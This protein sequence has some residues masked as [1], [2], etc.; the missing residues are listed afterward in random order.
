MAVTKGLQQYTYSTQYT[1]VKEALWLYLLQSLKSP[2]ESNVFPTPWWETVPYRQFQDGLIF[3]SAR[4][5]FSPA[6]WDGVS[7]CCEVPSVSRVGAPGRKMG[8]RQALLGG[9][10]GFGLAQGD[11]PLSTRCTTPVSPP[12]TF[13]CWGQSFFLTFDLGTPETGARLC[14]WLGGHLAKS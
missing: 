1:V 3:N 12:H 14:P 8:Q 7:W 6:C 11:S 10:A 5:V 9:A 2:E 13:S 4:S